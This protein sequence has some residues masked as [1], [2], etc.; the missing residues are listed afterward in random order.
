MIAANW[1]IRQ[2]EFDWSAEEEAEFH[3]WLREAPEHEAAY[4]RLECIYRAADCLQALRPAVDSAVQ[5]EGGRSFPKWLALAASLL[6]LLFGGGVLHY[7]LAPRHMTYETVIGGH[8]KVP[9]ADGSRLELDTDTKVRTEIMADQRKVWLDRGEVYFEVAHDTSRPFV[10]WAGTRKITVVGTKFA[11]RHTDDGLRVIVTEGRVRVGP[12]EGQ[13]ATEKTLSKGEALLIDG[14]SELVINDGRARMADQLSWR[15]GN[16]MFNQNTLADA[17]EEFNRYNI[18]KL[19][20]S[21]GDVA[22]LTIS[23]QFQAA[24]VEGFARL[25]HLA[26]GLEVRNAGDHIIISQ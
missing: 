22:K 15:Q 9:L 4:Y 18:K 24:N 7:S 6:L 11:V 10:V 16:L 13:T 19:V 25:L 14:S 23:G 12:A 20:I 21:N 2:D 1:L 17:A 5:P 26:Y 3:C 8:S